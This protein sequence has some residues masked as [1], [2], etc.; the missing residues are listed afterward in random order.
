M[1]LSSKHASRSTRPGSS[2]LEPA[3]SGREARGSWVETPSRSATEDTMEEEEEE[4][5]EEERMGLMVTLSFPSN[6]PGQ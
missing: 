1:T 2:Q 4:E 3:L 6:T 5:E